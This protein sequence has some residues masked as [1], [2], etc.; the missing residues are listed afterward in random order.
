LGDAQGTARALITLA[1]AMLAASPT[2]IASGDAPT[3]VY[4]E[5]LELARLARDSH[6]ESYS[7]LWLG[8]IASWQ[9]DEEQARRLMEASLHAA[10][11]AGDLWMVAF[12]TDHLGHLALGAG[13]PADA[14]AYHERALGIYRQ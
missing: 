9:G 7:L 4:E 1:L 11:R 8:R 10:S 14:L 5:A 3:P 13:E 12:A 6:A 2:A